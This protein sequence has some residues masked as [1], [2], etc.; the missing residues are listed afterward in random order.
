MHTNTSMADTEYPPLLTAVDARSHVHL[1][2]GC[3]PLASARCTRSAEVGACPILI[4]PAL[5][6]ADGDVGSMCSALRQNVEEGKV[7]WLQ[8]RFEDDDVKTLGR[9]EVDGFVDAVFVT[10]DARDPLSESESTLYTCMY[11]SVLT[12]WI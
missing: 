8:R 1:I 3:N 5:A 9:E 2:V 6:S 4:A 12:W 7:Q 11:V 10:V